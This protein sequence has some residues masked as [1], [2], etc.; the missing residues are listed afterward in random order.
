MFDGLASTLGER[1]ELNKVGFTIADRWSYHQWLK[2]NPTFEAAG[3]FLVKEWE[4]TANPNDPPNFER[5]AQ[6]EKQLSWQDGRGPGV[7]G[8]IVADRRLLM[9]P[10]CTYT[11][12]YRRRFTD[13]QHL[14]ILERACEAMEQAFD[15]VKPD[16][17]VGFICNSILEYLGF[18]FARARGIRYLNLRTSRIENRILLSDSHRDPAP[19]VVATYAAGEGIS[20]TAIAQAKQ[21][22]LNAREV[23]AKYEGV[24]SPSSKPARKVPTPRNPLSAALRFS[25]SLSEYRSSGA[26]DDNHCPGLI[27]PLWFSTVRN[28][29][30]ARKTKKMLGP[31]YVSA[32]DLAERRFAVF[33]LH[34]EPEI[35]LTLYGRPYLNQV[36]VIRAI[37][38]SLPADMV[39]V[40]KEHP[41]MVGKR[42]L[43]MYK[44]FLN[45]PRVRLAAPE[46]NL[47]DLITKSS[48]VTLLTGSSSLEASILE[49]PVVALG[50]NM[51]TL[52]PDSMAV[53]CRDLT[54]LPEAISKLLNEH[55]HDE[56]SLERLYAAIVENTTE[57][58][59]YS[60]LLGRTNSYSTEDRSRDADLNNLATF[61]LERAQQ[62]MANV[63][64]GYDVGS[65]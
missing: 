5:L 27:R 62:P 31:Q 18:L 51:V 57:V 46:L 41:W 44:K 59:L 65:W 58:N 29:I 11:Q 9:G 60:G 17:V 26:A 13:A 4:I 56:T 38:L 8:A 54:E 45:I 32:K 15:S 53:R 36:E 2:T 55:E 3:H 49:K 14:C 33:P 34:T 47:R 64:K 48:L 35:S 61:L 52:L 21:L 1:T 20:N 10:D 12:D 28:P 23:S 30:L 19:E 25:R 63:P 24:V 40:I 22:I 37:A 39:L 6:F 16:L 42:S 43:G 50:P 7:F